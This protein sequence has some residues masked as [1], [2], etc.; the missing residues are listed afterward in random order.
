MTPLSDRFW[1]KVQKTETCWIWTGARR[2]EGY[3]VIGGGPRGSKTLRATHVSYE[4][5]VG[6]IPAGQW[7]LHRCD[8][9]R[10]VR[11]DHLF[12]GTHQ[13]NVDDAKAKGRAK[14]PPLHLGEKCHLAKITAEQVREI[15]AAAA[16]G[17]SY[18][19][20]AKRYPLSKDGVGTI[21]RRECWKDVA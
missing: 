17:E 3:G 7:V 11:P 9:P 4:L 6:P 18:S 21:V 12:L 15:R 5:N 13:D 16:A 1:L 19:S 2:P 14:N 20:I 10:C 8:N